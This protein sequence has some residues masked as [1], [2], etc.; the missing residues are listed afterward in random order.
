MD[1]Y[2]AIPYDSHSFPETHPAQLAALALLFGVEAPD[3]RCCRVLELGCAAGGNLIPMA[4]FLR[5]SRFLGIELSAAQ[6]L[7]GQ[8]R[9]EALGLTNITI[10]QGDLGG[11]RLEGGRFD[12]IIAHGLYSWVPPPVRTALL[13]LIRHHLS[14]HGV[15]YVSFNALPGWRMRGML[16][17]MLLYHVQEEQEP[18]QRLAA[19]REFLPFLG[20]CIEGLDALSAS[21][22]RR[23]LAHLERAP[24]SYLYHEYLAAVND[25]VLFADFAAAAREQE[26]DWLCNTELQYQIPG[27]QGERVEALV[28]AIPDRLERQQ[29]LDFVLNR[30]FHQSLLVHREQLHA[31]TPD[32]ERF[33]HLSLWA[34]LHLPRKLD[35][36]KA[37]PQSFADAMGETHAVSHPL[38]KAALDHLA[39]VYPAS[40][41]HGELEARAR[42][43]VRDQGDPRLS[44]QPEHLFGELFSLF[45][46]R[47]VQVSGVPVASPPAV[48]EH[49]RLT[50]LAFNGLARGTLVGLHH[51]SLTLEPAL[52][53]LLSLLDGT[54][55][56][57][58]L[59][60]AFAV[61]QGK[62][63]LDAVLARLQR[64]GALE[65]D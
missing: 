12:Y 38:T 5:E 15:A 51:E 32:Y 11:A 33:A 55:D 4:W 62:F 61:T 20:Q 8:S 28:G 63:P 14:P 27:A 48:G 52:T 39:R 41:T 49:P 46:R 45:A 34:D 35:L 1:V 23:E 3:P 31:D 58:A 29:Y 6:V 21:Y 60:A 37:K 19:A 56:R 26:L 2:D 13:R 25:P 7:D 9:I 16:R 24:D 30:N 57:A 42:L 10:Q 18:D 53:K 40:V 50:P 36:R 17:D 65:A 47:V 44:Q 22:L 43:R 64:L 59:R 54:R